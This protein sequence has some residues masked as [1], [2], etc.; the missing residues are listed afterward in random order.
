MMKRF[1]CYAAAI[2][3][4]CISCANAKQQGE[5]NP[6][7]TVRVSQVEAVDKPDEVTG[8]GV[9]SFLQKNDISA[10]QEGEIAAIYYR[11]G[12]E[13]R[14]GQILAL[15]KNPRLTIAVEVSEEEYDR[16][17]SAYQLAKI[18]LFEGEFNAEAELLSLERAEGELSEKRRYHGEQVRKFDQ[19]TTLYA[20][21][22]VNEESI[23]SARF[24]IDAQAAQL[25]LSALDI[26]IRKI[27]FRDRDLQAAG[28][29]VS[30]DPEEKMKD[31]IALATSSLRVESQAAETGKEMAWKNLVSAKTAEAELKI[32][33]PVSGFIAARNF[34]TGDHVKKDDTLFTVLN[35][36]SLYATV[37]VRETDAFR[38][39]KGMPAVVRVDGT[40]AAYKAT[41]DLVS[42]IADAQSFMFN[43][44]ILID[45]EELS[46]T[47]EI[48]S[49]KPGMFA[50]ARITVG[51]PD[52][53]IVIDDEAII[54]RNKKE[55]VV[56]VV[57]DRRVTTRSVTFGE[58][59]ENKR[60]I[61]TGLEKGEL[62]VLKPASGL[63]DLS[64]LKE[65]TY[66]QIV[67]K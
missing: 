65:G 57:Q 60:E 37:P 7:V 61:I 50:E 64:H 12:E 28:M 14:E 33:S 23:R 31:L 40:G 67:K 5:E 46:K 38:V 19:Q 13:V 8:F 45:A 24:E 4:V 18:R 20:V 39:K 1:V 15:L 59:H 27:G 54:N 43:V 44:R 16:A 22:G 49:A 36:D 35:A 30:D 53:I 9:L 25:E 42:P 2:F 6:A 62:V 48:G 11:E 58:L 17:E 55:G 63:S 52:S 34:E 21:G 51:E 10:R 56:Y 32:I 66:V 26:E 47:P 3:V 29:E 41:V